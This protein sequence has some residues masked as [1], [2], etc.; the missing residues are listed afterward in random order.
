MPGNK[1]HRLDSN[2]CSVL[3]AEQTGAPSMLWY[4]RKLADDIGNSTA[5]VTDDQL[6]SCV[7]LPVAHAKLDHPERLSL[8]PGPGHMAS[9]ALAAH[10][11]GQR[12]S[13]SFSTRNISHSKDVLKIVL[14]DPVAELS[15]TQTYQLDSSCSVLSIA[16]E[17]VNHGSETLQIDW[18]AACTLPLPDSFAEQLT[19]NGRWGL[20]FQTSRTAIGYNQTR[21]ENFAG[22]TSHEHFPGCVCG[23]PGFN[24]QSG[25]V[26]GIHL[27][28]SGNYRLI[29]ER[30]SDGSA[31]V[32]A[33]CSY[34]PGEISIAPGQSMR[35]PVAHACVAVGLTEMSHRFHQFAR[36]EIL[37][38][39]T[40]TARPVHANSWEALYFEHSTQQ[41]CDLVD[42][43]HIAGAE[44]FV[45]DDGW[46]EGRRND[47]AGLGDWRVDTGIYPEGLHPLVDH[48]RA[49]GMQFG[50]WIEPEMVNPDSKLYREHPEW[51]LHVEGYETPLARHQ[52]VLNLTLPE[53]QSY[54]FQSIEAL[55]SE[56]N[57][58]YIKWDMNRDLL[59]AG[60]DGQAATSRQVSSVYNLLEQINRRFPELEIES[61]ASGGARADFGILAYTG[62]I[63]T[64]D[65]IDPIDRLRIQQGFSLFFPPEIMGSHV[66]HNVAHLTGRS[67][68]LHT[69][70]AI[71]LQG[72]YGFEMDT[73]LLDEDDLSVLFPYTELYKRSSHW[74]ADSRIWRID[75]RE[76]KLFVYG[77]VAADQKQSIWTIAAE[78]SLGSVMPERLILQGLEANTVYKVTAIHYQHLSP[79][80]RKLPDW[81]SATPELGGEWLMTIGLTLPILPAQAALVVECNA[82]DSPSTGKS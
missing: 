9:P 13:A 78:A 31:Y 38:A 61:C 8:F 22:R 73:R 24:E 27:A 3:F 54:L 32:Q 63:W 77:M 51:A 21:I 74:I 5:T 40:R 64:S 67:T 19:L 62:R 25:S 57:I 15:V 7:D 18:L 55:V 80:N 36:T 41:L 39:W 34:L 1:I 58:D 6:L 49:K 4:G 46:F 56:Y 43:A 10:S 17:L 42:A 2:E 68:S 72:Q 11:N 12:F 52:L 59:F 20:E 23:E 60:N 79:Y 48:V 82:M 33:G 26:L 70:A 30:L 44:R 47:T 50:L 28:Y 53:V 45:L 76:E 66:G 81:L 16:T 14:H 29:V 69:R 35:S 65:S 75:T 71:A 37:P